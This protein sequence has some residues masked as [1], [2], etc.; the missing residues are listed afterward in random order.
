MEGIKGPLQ[1]SDDRLGQISLDPWIARDPTDGTPTGKHGYGKTP[2][3]TFEDFILLAK[4]KLIDYNE[5][6]GYFQVSD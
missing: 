3:Q 4:E 1:E 5:L 6:K 2:L